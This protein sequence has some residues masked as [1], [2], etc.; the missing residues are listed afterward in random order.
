[1]VETMMGKK[2]FRENKCKEISL[3][4]RHGGMGINVRNLQ[5]ESDE[6]RRKCILTTQ[7]LTNKLLRQD[8]KIPLK[9]DLKEYR[10]SNERKLKSK[11]NDLILQEPN[12]TE[13]SRM[14]ENSL[15]GTNNWMHSIPISNQSRYFNNHEFQDA[16]RLRMG[17][18]LDGLTYKC[19]CGKPNSTIHAKN[20]KNGGYIDM[21]HNKIR[22]FIHQ[23][24][25]IAYKD[26]ETEPMLRHIDDQ[27]LNPGANIQDAARADIR[28]KGCLRDYQ[29]AF[30]DVEI[31]N[32]QA[33]SHLKDT[34]KEAMKKA[35]ERK[36]K[37]YKQRV[38]TVENGI[39]CPLIFTTKRARTMKSS[40]VIRK[41]SS[42]IASKRGE[43]TNEVSKR[44]STDLSYL[45]LRAELA[46]IRGSRRPRLVT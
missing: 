25:K 33:D 11:S 5:E 17:V 35:E 8:P 32:T 2:I 12:K 22:D 23:K 4:T 43:K 37:L 31:I 42:K 34:P 38:Q 20:C 44:I 10:K 45:F 46:C 13:V 19:I 14:R 30:F 1:M 26:T 36:D 29:N 27:T 24:A 6:Q 28:I 41:I 39:F 21:R 7:D 15:K 16:T 9:P 3:P 18:N 40:K